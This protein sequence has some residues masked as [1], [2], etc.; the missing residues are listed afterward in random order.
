MK[1][2]LTI[3]TLQTYREPYPP[4]S[5]WKSGRLF[6]Y[7]EDGEYRAMTSVLTLLEHDYD[8]LVALLMLGAR[9]ASVPLTLTYQ[10]ND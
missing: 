9:A 10:E 6:L 3:H 4:W 8:E 2:T 1:I 5:V 7:T